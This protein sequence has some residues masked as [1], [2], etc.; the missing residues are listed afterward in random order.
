MKNAAAASNGLCLLAALACIQRASPAFA[1]DLH[2]KALVPIAERAKPA[3]APMEFV[4]APWF[5]VYGHV[6]DCAT[7]STWSKDSCCVC[8]ERHG[9][10]PVSL[11]E[12]RRKY[13]ELNGKES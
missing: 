9:Y 8:V 2:T 11:A 1:Y 4:K 12:I 3:G 13:E 10:R 5:N 7:Y 6:H